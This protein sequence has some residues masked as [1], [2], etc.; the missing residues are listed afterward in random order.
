MNS[1]YAKIAYE[2]YTKSTNNKSLISGVELPPFDELKPEIKEAWSQSAIAVAL[3]LGIYVT[4][5]DE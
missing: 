4:K 3:E 5:E 1:K 2:G